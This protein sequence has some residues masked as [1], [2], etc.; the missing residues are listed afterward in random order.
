M[1]ICS[2][3]HNFQKTSYISHAY[4]HN[5]R[6]LTSYISF[7][8]NKKKSCEGMKEWWELFAT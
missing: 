7:K 8:N 4:P 1:D 3:N 6:I 5:A 2:Y